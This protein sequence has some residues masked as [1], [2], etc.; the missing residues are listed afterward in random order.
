MEI[1]QGN[2]L[3]T[4]KEFDALTPEAR[5]KYLA[6]ATA[7]VKEFNERNPNGLST[8][9]NITK[10]NTRAT[11]ENPRVA[12]VFAANPNI[13]TE[14]LTY[15]PSVLEAIADDLGCGGV[16]A[17]ASIIQNSFKPCKIKV[18]LKAVNAGDT[19]E[20]KDNTVGTYKIPQIVIDG[21]EEYILS[22]DA[23]AYVMELNQE[24]DRAEIMEARSRKRDNLF[25]KAK[26]AVKAPVATPAGD[27]DEDVEP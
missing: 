11:G 25:G 26:P 23:K 18:V 21:R 15:P 6:A 16:T 20:K 22:D 27:V 10:V 4:T 13:K 24:A 12:V 7:F 1:T 8:T 2:Q 19:Y 17:F 3:L 5:K 14:A 9:F